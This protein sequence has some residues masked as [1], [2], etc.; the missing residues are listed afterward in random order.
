MTDNDAS[1]QN[2]SNKLMESTIDDSANVEDKKSKSEKDES[3]AM[4]KLTDTKET[5]NDDEIDSALSKNEHKL[6]DA[7]NRLYEQQ[8]LDRENE[9][10]T[11]RTLS[12]VKVAASD[13]DAIQERF[14]IDRLTA[15]HQLRI[16]NGSL[17]NCIQT[18]LQS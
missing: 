15:E 5:S 8:K 11:E 3:F 17:K 18:L 7:L 10:Q 6:K 1:I 12:L 9:L 13:I 4:E 16:A 2:T 14:L